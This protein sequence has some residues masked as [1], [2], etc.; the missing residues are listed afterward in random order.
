MSTTITVRIGRDTIAPTLYAVLAPIGGA[1]RAQVCSLH[2]THVGAHRHLSPGRV[3]GPVPA[4]TC[5]LDNVPL[6]TTKGAIAREVARVLG[7]EEYVHVYCG[8]HEGATATIGDP[9][10]PTRGAMLAAVGVEALLAALAATAS[11]A[12]AAA[13]VAAVETARAAEVSG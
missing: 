5:V 8:G 11:D 6:T 1:P 10:S 7:E 2:T 4:T 12:G 13:L 3:V 9:T